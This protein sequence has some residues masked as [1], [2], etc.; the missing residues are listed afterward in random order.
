MNYLTVR[1]RDKVMLIKQGTF[2]DVSLKK[3]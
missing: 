3:A 2:R 1:K